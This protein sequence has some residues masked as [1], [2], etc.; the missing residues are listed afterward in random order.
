MHLVL[1]E[2]NYTALNPYL[3][4]EVGVNHGGSLELAKKQIELAAESGAHAVKFQTYKADKIASKEHSRAYWNRTYEPTSS[5]HELFSKY[6]AFEP[7]DYLYLAEVC[8]HNGVEFLST[9]FDEEAAIFLSFQAAVKIA[10]ADLTNI[11]LRR[12]IAALGKPVLLSTGASTISEVREAITD[13]KKH[14][15]ESLT[16]LHCVLRYPTEPTNANLGRISVLNREFG[17]EAA[18]GYS[19][20]VR[21]E[22]GEL[23]QLKVAVELG[24]SVIEKH[25]THDKGMGGN[26]H[27][28]AMDA[29]DLRGF[30]EYLAKRRILLTRDGSD[31]IELQAEARQHARRRIFFAQDV[32]SGSTIRDDMIVA[33]RG[34]VGLEVS[35]WDSIVGASLSQP[36]FLG[37]PLTHAHLE[38]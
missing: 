1:G 38:A 24:A 12:R 17:D 35:E 34:D 36:G 23:A 6:D 16:L 26:D 32:P 19:D 28:H 11:P 10:S 7:R 20:H 29:D 15:A 25:F 33:L 3:I 30:V 2:R 21:M 9:P 8:K 37:E 5:Q 27:Y 4:A 18:I 13:L 22:N 14:G 31:D